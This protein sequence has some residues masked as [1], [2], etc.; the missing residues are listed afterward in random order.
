MGPF[1][2]KNT[3]KTPKNDPKN[4]SKTT[5]SAP[6]TPQKPLKNTQ[7]SSQKTPTLCTISDFNDKLRIDPK[8][9]LIIP[10]FRFCDYTPCS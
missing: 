5:Y 8:K 4:P 3:P 2:L 10:L 9:P 7:K 6:K 1:S